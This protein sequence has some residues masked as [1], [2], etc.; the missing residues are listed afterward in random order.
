MGYAC[1][2][3]NAN[4]VYLAGRT[5]GTSSTSFQGFQNSYGG[6]TSDA[7]IVKFSPSGSRI[8]ATYYGGSE[9][10]GVRDISVDAANQVYVAGTTQSS[11]NIF[12]EGFQ[13]TIQNESGFV[14]K[15]GCPNP[16]LLNLPFE[17][18][19]NSSI[20][21]SPYPAGGTLQLLGAGVLSNNT[22][23][24]PDV[25]ENSTVVIQ[26]STPV[27]STCPSTVNNFEIN[28][29]PNVIASVSLNT[30]D[31]EICD[32]D[33]ATFSAN[34]QNAGNDPSIQWFVNNELVLEGS[35]DYTTS[36][37]VNNDIVQVIIGS[38]NICATPSEVQSNPINVNVSPL[39]DVSL[40]F[41][42]LEDGTL[43][44]DQGFASYQWFFD[45][46]L[47]PDANT[48]NYVPAANGVYTVVVTNEF[49]CENSASTSVVALSVG[50]QDMVGISIYPNP[51]DGQFSIDF[52]TQ[53]P[54]RFTIS[55]AIGE[56]I[57]DNLNVKPNETVIL[58]KAAP[59]LYFVIS[60]RDGVQHTQK[61]IIQ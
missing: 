20:E 56:I 2:T 1:A 16:Q 32:N 43:V 22:Y 25:I 47:I 24:A 8:W 41:T 50:E 52:G 51:N 11:N 61:L 60:Q 54:D 13:S 49:G 18:C 21:L 9:N 12:F 35:N 3:D 55:N 19:A 34:I 31:I 17:I 5:N 39:P 59:G 27:S 57:L 42:N 58:E 26:Y 46:E 36:T 53:T 40:V 44:T 30:G 14:A 4:N 33:S 45:G 38:S 28:I 15:I 23:T 10:D 29:L 48:A 37:L 7:Y 6:G